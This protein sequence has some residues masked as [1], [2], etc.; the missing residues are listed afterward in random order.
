MA[1]VLTAVMGC[2]AVVGAV[3]LLDIGFSGYSM[4]NAVRRY[5]LYQEESPIF[6]WLTQR[7][8]LTQR[9]G[10][11]FWRAPVVVLTLGLLVAFSSGVSEWLCMAASLV[12]VAIAST[13][14]GF[15]LFGLVM[16]TRVHLDLKAWSRLQFGRTRSGLGEPQPINPLIAK[17]LVVLGIVVAY[18]A[19]YRS[20]HLLQ[21][22]SFN[23]VTG[24]FD[25][26]TALY[27][28]VTTASTVGYGDI[29]AANDPARLAAISQIALTVAVIAILVSGLLT[30][31]ADPISIDRAPGPP[32]DVAS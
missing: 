18:A 27:F 32:P 14:F 23:R 4:M 2:L 6:R 19:L 10:Y 31:T 20:I 25:G 5:E 30:K 11:V 1:Q 28:S 21:P 29:H 26:V 17:T 22:M 24:G 16:E 9:I 15:V 13:P 7:S 12:C 3:K 8:P